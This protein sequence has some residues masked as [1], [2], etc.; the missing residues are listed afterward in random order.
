MYTLDNLDEPIRLMADNL[1]S[2]ENRKVC[3]HEAVTEAVKQLNRIED[4]LKYLQKNLTGE[5]VEVVKLVNKTSIIDELS[6]KF[7][8]LLEARESELMYVTPQQIP[9]SN[10]LLN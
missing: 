5:N 6:I 1:E 10:M 3:F 9:P 7:D 2:L 4:I 8:K